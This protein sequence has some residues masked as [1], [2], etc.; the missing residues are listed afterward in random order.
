MEAR[1]CCGHT[2]GTGGCESQGSS[3]TVRVPGNGWA[4]KEPPQHGRSV[5]TEEWFREDY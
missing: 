1:G 5:D 2:V 3:R 4:E